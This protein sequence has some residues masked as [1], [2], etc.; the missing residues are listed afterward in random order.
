M[1]SFA[2][3]AVHTSGRIQKGHMAAANENELA[4]VLRQLDLEL[5]EARVQRKGLWASLA[6]NRRERI[7]PLQKITLCSQLEDLLRAGLPFADS[8]DLVI[9]AMPHG[10]TQTRLVAIAGAIRS[11]S[12]VSQAFGQHTRLFDPVFLAILETGERSGNLAE[13]FGRLAEQLRWQNAIKREMYRALRYPLFLLCVVFGVT[14]FMMGFV[15]P[16]IV[17]FLT[18]LG[19]ELPFSTR[20]LIGCADLFAL[21]WWLIPLLGVLFALG[22]ITGRRTSAVFTEKTDGWLLRLPGL[23]SLFHKMAL[24]RF[25]TSFSHLLK[26]GLNLQDSLRLAR[27]T[28]ENR[29]LC[30]RVNEAA[31]HVESGHALSQAMAT[32]F[33]PLILQMIKVGEKSGAMTKAFHEIARSYETDIRESVSAFLGTLEPALTLLVGAFLAWIVLAVLGP[34]YGSLGSM[35]GGV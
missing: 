26:S 21:A 15:V 11:G 17:L 5:I 29:F 13:S 20:L 19:T 6:E 10:L 7:D 16:E 9:E 18:S 2:Y 30:A 22:L 14:S 33:P 31:A 24:G 1:T 3:R 25:A 28:L 32:L 27:G 12:S 4:F 34:V 8:L 35:S 23:G